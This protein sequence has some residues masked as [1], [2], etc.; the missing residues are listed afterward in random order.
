M[1][2]YLNLLILA[3]IIT[4]GGCHTSQDN[5]A[6]QSTETHV[7][8]IKQMK[9]VPDTLKVSPGDSIKWINR[10]LVTH[11]VAAKNSGQWKSG[12]LKPDDV[13]TIKAKKSSSYFC[14]LHPVM[15][16]TIIIKR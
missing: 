12:D 7:V 9:F 10:D 15:K 1:K 3:W 2:C 13:F 11:N 16:G 4:I 5:P 14:P 6:D 8:E